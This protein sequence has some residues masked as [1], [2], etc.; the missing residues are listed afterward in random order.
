MG[1]KTGIRWTQ[2]TWNPWIGCHQVSPGC[3]HC[4][5]KALEE[6]WGR[7]F[8]E[9]RR[10]SPGTFRAP[11]KWTKPAM[12]FTCSMSDFF[13]EAADVW[14]DEAWE[15][16]RHTPHLTYQVLTKR[17]ERISDHLPADWGDGYPNV[18]LGVSVENQYWA[19][20][21][22][23]IL[24]IVPAVV[25]FLSCEPLLKALDLRRWLPQYLGP[26]SIYGNAIGARGRRIQGVLSW[27]IVGG[28]SG[29][30]KQ[31]R[32]MDLEWARDIQ[33]QCAE[34]GVAYFFKQISARYPGQGRDA[35][36]RLYEEFPEPRRQPGAREGR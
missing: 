33:R 27:V 36:G 31:R 10:T 30:D 3:A 15:I 24:G 22:I 14:R 8:S 32:P 11:L 7:D 23:P 20:R 17:P 34:A 16:I 2:H 5:A 13:H 6:R 25:R 12:V 29:P 35:L 21:R 28:E 1:E 9:V 19:D 4:Y 26:T 18:W